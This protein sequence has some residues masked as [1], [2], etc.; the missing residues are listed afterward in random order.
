ML[1]KAL[2]SVLKELRNRRRL[3]Q[4]GLAFRADLHRTYISQLERCL[5][6]PGL[7]TLY[8]ISTALELKLSTLLGMIEKELEQ[9][10]A[11]QR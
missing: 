7:E 9:D 8:K 11:K 4:E 2:A 3:S 5:K 1:E 6:S 10:R